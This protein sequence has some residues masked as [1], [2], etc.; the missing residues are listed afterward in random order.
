MSQNMSF[1]QMA[2]R[3]S[4]KMQVVHELRY[5]LNP[6]PFKVPN[7]F[8]FFLKLDSMILKFIWKISRNS[9]FFKKE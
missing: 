5:M 7:G 6:I 4:T 9:N 3:H 2:R 1:S 8:F